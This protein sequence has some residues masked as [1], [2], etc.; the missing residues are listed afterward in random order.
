MKFHSKPVAEHTEVPTD[1]KWEEIVAYW[2]QREDTTKQS[3]TKHKNTCY[4]LSVSYTRDV[5][6]QQAQLSEI[7]SLVKAQGGH[8]VG[9]EVYYLARHDSQTLIGKGTAQNIA[10]RAH[11][12]GANM[13]VVDA[14]LSP[15]QMRNLEDASGIAI[16][17]REGIILNVFLRHAKTRSAK[18]QIE[19][20]QLQYLR[21]RIRGIGMDM[22]QQAG[23]ISGSRGAGETASELL[24]RKLDGRLA[25]LKKAQKKIERVG[26]KHRKQRHN[27]KRITLL[28]YT[29][30]GKTSLMNALVGEQLSSRNMPFETLDTTSRSLSRHGGDVIISD[31]VGFIRRLPKSLLPSFESTLAEICD[32]SLLV[33]VIDLSDYEW[34]EHLRIVHQ[35]IDKLHAQKIPRFYVFNKTDRVQNMPSFEMLNT[36]T[37]DHKC[38]TLS[39]KDDEAVTQLKDKLLQAVRS[40][41]QTLEISVPHTA[42]HVMSLI[43]GKTRILHSEATEQHMQFSI[44][45]P[46]H[47]V[48]KIKQE[49]RK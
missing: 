39:S 10:A 1:D 14:E 47:I 17:D 41:E 18:I 12:L 4:V 26:S 34:C 8:I 49:L 13:L 22:D 48:A 31:T 33:V 46:V 35:M 28:G 3:G 37:Y 21:P 36:L 9:E 19:I 15:S 11:E 32:A 16:C 45:A 25:E 40:E 7:T 27:S 42:S 20:A 24:A 38:V 43:Y 23:G 5:N 6:V 29:N 30:A 2:N 44:Q